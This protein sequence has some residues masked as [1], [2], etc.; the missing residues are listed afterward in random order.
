MGRGIFIANYHNTSNLWSPT[1]RCASRNC[2]LNMNEMSGYDGEA[3][4][5]L[6]GGQLMDHRKETGEP[7]SR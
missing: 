4:G 6:V 2:K 7:D 3:G 1:G 5:D